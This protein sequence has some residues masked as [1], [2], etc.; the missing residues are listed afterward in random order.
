TYQVSRDGQSGKPIYTV[1]ADSTF[2]NRPYLGYTDSGLVPG[3]TH[4]YRLFAFDPDGNRTAGD[5]VTYTVPAS[6]AL[7]SYGSQL[8]ADGASNYYPLNEPSG[9]T[10]FDN[11]GYTDLV[12]TGTGITRGAAGAIAGDAATTFDGT[13]GG[14][15]SNVG[16]NGPNNFTV[17]LWFKT[18]T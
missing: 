10:V 16:Q 4:T 3:S 17:S 13:A 9:T 2:W 1:T 12:A 11:A 14:V 7:T 15:Y 18:T 5:T 6:A 8:I